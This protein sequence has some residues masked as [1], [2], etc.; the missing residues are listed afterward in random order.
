VTFQ[1]RDFHRPGRSPVYATEA[2]A[3]TSH[4]LATAAA[5]EMLK[6]GGTAA[7]AAIA[8]VGV[9]AVVEPHMTGIGGDCF[10]LVSKP[11][12]PIWGYNGSG[13]AAKAATAAKLRAEG[14]TAIDP[15]SVHAITVPGAIEAWEQ[16]LKA[17]GRFGLGRVLQPAIRYAKEGWPVTPRVAFDWATDVGQLSKDAGAVRHYLIDGRA[18]RAGER[19]KSEALGGTLEEIAKHGARGFYEG[20]VAEDMVR[21]M[22][23][24]GGLLSL[25]DLAAHKGSAETPVVGDY[26]GIGIAELPPNGQGITALILLNILEQFDMKS[27][28]PA[29]PE[30]L[31]L[32]IE[33]ARIAYSLRDTHIADPAHMR[34]TVDQLVSKDFAKVLAG[35]IDP[36]RRTPRLVPPP[37]GTNTIYCTIV[38]RDRMAVSFINSI[39]HHFGTKICAPETGI[40]LQSRGSSF[41]LDDNHPNCIGP[42]KRPMHTIIPAMMVENGEVT[43]SFGV[44]GGS[45]QSSG[46][47]HVVCNTVDYGMDPQAAIDS[48]RAFFDGEKTTIEPTWPAATMEKVRAMGHSVDV[49]TKPIGG[50]Q[51]IRIEKSGLLVGGS[52]PRKD[53]LALGY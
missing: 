41:N 5:I 23:A 6:A 31:H 19:M 13:R 29:S 20:R 21:T 25:E 53:G 39:F 32:G 9:M 18:P 17:H 27:L 12:K 10:T 50:G 46:H 24:K 36:G 51:M 42:G 37:P 33:A 15:N 34:A 3:A 40:L 28:D 45:Y 48:P 52:D 11:G 44:M 16:I 35:M 30:R 26:K 47:A 22:K 2:M 7:D 4:P 43:C 8:A 38:D 1:T 14:L 49:T